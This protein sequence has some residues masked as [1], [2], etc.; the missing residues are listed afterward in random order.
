MWLLVPDFEAV[1]HMRYTL[2]KHAQGYYVNR[3]VEELCK[4]VHCDASARFNQGMWELGLCVDSVVNGTHL[5][6]WN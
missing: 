5:C 1:V 4:V 3:I 6:W 2:G